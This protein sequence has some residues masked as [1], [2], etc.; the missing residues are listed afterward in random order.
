MH[1]QLPKDVKN[2]RTNLYHEDPKVPTMKVGNI[3]PVSDT[4]SDSDDDTVP[5][6][7]APTISDDEDS[8]DDES[9]EN[10]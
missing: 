4:E 2:I 1:R 10:K 5:P 6:L 3:K 7:I 8:S 9:E